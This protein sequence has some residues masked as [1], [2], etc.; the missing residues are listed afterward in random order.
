M[1]NKH[2]LDAFHQGKQLEISVLDSNENLEEYQVDQESSASIIN[3]TN[4]SG[5]SPSCFNRPKI[6]HPNNKDECTFTKVLKF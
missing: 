4:R 6:I 1:N 3:L 5:L 2:I